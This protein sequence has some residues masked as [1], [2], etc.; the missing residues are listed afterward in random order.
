MNI[1]SLFTHPHAVPNI[2]L[3]FF[4]WKKKE[5][6]KNKIAMKVNGVQNIALI[7]FVYLFLTWGCENDNR[8]YL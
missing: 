6:L 7:L 5:I 8:M 4:L 1:L 3:Y 2:W